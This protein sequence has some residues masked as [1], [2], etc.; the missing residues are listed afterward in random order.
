[1]IFLLARSQFSIAVCFFTPFSLFS[2]GL[3]VSIKIITVG[4]L[5][6]MTSL[7]SD[8]LLLFSDG[9]GCCRLCFPRNESME[10]LIKR[11]I[12]SYWIIVWSN[13][14][15]HQRKKIKFKIERAHQTNKRS[16]ICIGF[17]IGFGFRL[18]LDW[19]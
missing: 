10:F 16:L 17:G 3:L 18:N 2:K 11:F 5:G 14:F 19:I 4:E 6:I 8:G 7:H 13:R 15:V 9:A 1:M 12:A